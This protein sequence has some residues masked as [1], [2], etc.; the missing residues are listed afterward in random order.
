MNEPI[1]RKIELPEY[2]CGPTIQHRGGDPK[3][4]HDYPP[5][6]TCSH[7]DTVEWYNCSKCGM[8]TGFE[9]YD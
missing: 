6:T 7:N 8:R 2:L 9:V 1:C 3:C 5:E 4:D